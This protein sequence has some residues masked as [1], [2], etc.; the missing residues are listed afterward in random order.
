MNKEKIIVRD[1][2]YIQTLSIVDEQ[3][4][5]FS[6]KEVQLTGFIYKDESFA[7]DQ[8]VI[9]RYVVSCCVADA[10]VYGFWYKIWR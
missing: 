2:Q 9:S 7:A 1:E 6:G 3:L 5:Q 8:A 4:A 10:S